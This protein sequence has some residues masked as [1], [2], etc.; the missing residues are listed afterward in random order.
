VAK[1]RT[2]TLYLG[3]GVAGPK[4]PDRGGGEFGID[5]DGEGGI[6]T[7][8]IKGF[9]LHCAQAGMF[10]LGDSGGGTGVG[11]GAGAGAIFARARSFRS[12]RLCTV[13]QAGR[14]GPAGASSGG[15]AGAGSG[16]SS[17]C[18]SAFGCH[19]GEYSPPAPCFD[20]TL[21]SS[22]I[23]LCGYWYCGW[24]LAGILTI[25]VGAAHR[26]AFQLQREESGLRSQVLC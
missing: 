23:S 7:G 22:A 15:G 12:A 20:F 11:A 26:A 24:A 16:G 8:A 1:N 5:A 9:G 25:A 10:G 18:L 13:R 4:R 19:S 2:R 17:A 3:G 14:A 21:M 6:G